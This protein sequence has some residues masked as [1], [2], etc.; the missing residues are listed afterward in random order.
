MRTWGMRPI[1]GVRLLAGAEY[2]STVHQQSRQAT[3]LRQ[4][5]T[6]APC[7]GPSLTGGDFR[8]LQAHLCSNVIRELQA[9]A[10]ELARVDVLGTCGDVRPV[11]AAHLRTHPR[12]AQLSRISWRRH[13]TCRADILI[14]R[15]YEKRVHLYL[16]QS[17]HTQ[18]SFQFHFL[19]F[20]KDR[21][22]QGA[23]C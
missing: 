10:V 4:P 12:V 6:R 5:I 8:R 13:A 2:A 21:C 11:T 1:M 14:S 23:A 16:V 15:V 19:G 7:T 3:L 22:V 17:Q 18:S 20:L 9:V